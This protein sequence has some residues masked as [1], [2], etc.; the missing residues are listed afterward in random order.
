[1]GLALLLVLLSACNSGTTVVVATPVPPDAGFRTYRHPGGAFSLRL[2]PEWSVRDL[3]G[4]SGVR[5]EFSPPGNAGL[6][7]SVRV[8]NTGEPLGASGLL[9]AVEHYPQML[10]DPSAYREM[11]RNA[12]GDGSWRLAGVRQTPIG[13]RQMNIFLQADGPFLTVVEADLTDLGQTELDRLTAVINTLR[14]DT[15]AAVAASGPPGAL[16]APD[17]AVDSPAGVMEFDNVS[18]WLSPRGEF[19]VGGLV[20]NRS[21]R[22]LEAIRIT[23]AL[24][25]AQ[26]QSLTEE[27]NLAPLEVLADGASSPF[28]V[29]FRSGRPAR[30]VGY[31]MSAAARYAEYALAGHLAA[32][33]FILGNDTATYNA[34]GFL[35]VSGDVVNRTQGAAYFVKAVVAVYDDS[36]R[37]VAADSVFVNDTELLPGE[38]ARFEVT[39]PELGG[40]AIRYT[41]DV[42][43][44][45]TPG[46]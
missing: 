22:P 10:A 34:N 21:G 30:A 17:S 16:P 1:V 2:P 44:K 23:A 37:V 31:E 20:T 38:V 46:G 26:G 40:N 8:S 25:D 15:N 33:Q 13:A 39:F 43:G 32:D 11:S 45:S 28:T 12:Q 42:E 3:S 18:A 7:L 41:I 27:S 5:V 29:R 35:I 14:I 24:V 4:E 6:P 36:S 19:V 9:E